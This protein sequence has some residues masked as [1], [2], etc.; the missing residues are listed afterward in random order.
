[1][2]R[3]DRSDISRRVVEGL[4][5][6]RAGSSLEVLDIFMCFPS[7]PLNTS[8]GMFPYFGVGAFPRIW[9]WQRLPVRC[10]RAPHTQKQTKIF[11]KDEHELTVSLTRILMRSDRTSG[12]IKISAKKLLR[13]REMWRVN[14]GCNESKQYTRDLH[15]K[16][17]EFF[18]TEPPHRQ[19]GM[20]S[21]SIGCC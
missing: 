2:W 12:D 9:R 11:T 15:N 13:E 21:A 8:R 10:S 1:M 3:T 16:V 7:S 20:N 17:E 14:K 4:H 5:G 19:V 18:P 6:S